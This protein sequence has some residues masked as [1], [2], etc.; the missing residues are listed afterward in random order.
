MQDARDALAYASGIGFREQF[1]GVVDQGS[2][3][4]IRSLDGKPT[5]GSEFFPRVYP[6]QHGMFGEEAVEFTQG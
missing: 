3:E 6:Q 5:A 1:C 2:K 4:I